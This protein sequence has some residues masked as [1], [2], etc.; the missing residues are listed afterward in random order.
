[1]VARTG[2]NGV[3]GDRFI[4][5]MYQLTGEIREQ[6]GLTEKKSAEVLALVV[7]RV[8]QEYGGRTPYVHSQTKTESIL[9]RWRDGWSVKKIAADIECTEDW[10]RRVVNSIPKPKMSES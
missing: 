6:A 4:D 10:V 3:S 7:S 1:M 2:V 8:Q 9:R 5:W